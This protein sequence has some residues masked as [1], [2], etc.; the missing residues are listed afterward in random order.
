M[1]ASLICTFYNEQDSI[2]DFI[3]SISKQKVKPS[4]VILVDGGSTDRS[5]KIVNK[6]IRQY[7]GK[8]QIK[9]FTKDGNRSVGRNEAVRKSSH[10]IILCSDAG[11]T[12]DVNWVKE[13]SKPFKN[14]KVDVVSGFYKPSFK[15]IFKP[16]ALKM[17]ISC[18]P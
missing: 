6:K 7:L 11:C 10:E 4:E 16:P 17:R 13:I 2:G 12:L 9:L 3:D 14:K 18:I 8:L 15:N 5:V 1:Q